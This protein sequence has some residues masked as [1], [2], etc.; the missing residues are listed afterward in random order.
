LSDAYIGGTGSYVGEIHV[1]SPADAVAPE[2]IPFKRNSWLSV[3]VAAWAVTPILLWTNGFQAPQVDQPP[4]GAKTWV[5]HAV[6]S[7]EPQPT[8]FQGRRFL[9]QAG[10]AQQVDSPPFGLAAWQT[11]WIEEEWEAQQRPRRFVQGAA[12]VADS[13]L[14]RSIRWVSLV[15]NAWEFDPPVIQA[16]IRAPIPTP[17]MPPFEANRWVA[18]VRQAWEPAAYKP[19]V[20]THLA[21]GVRADQPPGPDAWVAGVLEQWK[22]AWPRAQ[23][24]RYVVQGEIVD[25]LPFGAKPWAIRLVAMWQP[26][27]PDQVIYRHV[28]EGVFGP[29]NARGFIT[30]SDRVVGHITARDALA[31]AATATDSASTSI[32]QGDS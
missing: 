9:P 30:P 6:S 2:F 18:Q 16:R 5:E 21:Q 10:A 26:I 19:Q 29:P 1:G 13:P 8:V 7:W 14:P 32:T 11:S 31:S 28:T 27:P 17:D 15:R 22:P 25:D 3:V 20:L 24:K 12:V 23:E 4:S